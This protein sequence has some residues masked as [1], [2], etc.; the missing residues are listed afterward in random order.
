M[1]SASR[2]I[3]KDSHPTV[4]AVSETKSLKVRGRRYTN[5]YASSQPGAV[6]AKELAL[7][8]QFACLSITDDKPNTLRNV[9]KANPWQLNTIIMIAGSEEKAH[10]PLTT[11]LDDLFSLKLDHHMDISGLSKAGHALDTQGYIAHNDEIIVLAYRCTTSAKD[12]ITNLTTTSSAWELD[13]DVEQGHSGY[14]SSCVGFGC[15]PC[16]SPDKKSLNY[17]P[18]RVHT[19]F[20]NNFLVTVP[21]I[22]QYLDPLLLAPDQPPRTLYVVG[23]S[24]GAGIAIMA[25][26]YFLMEDQRYDWRNMPHKLRVVTAGGPRA[27]CQSMQQ[28]MDT[29]C[30]DLRYTD[31]VVLARMVRDKDVV[32]T[33]PPE[34]FGFRHLNEKLVYITKESDPTETGGGGFGEVLVNPDLRQVLSK[35]QVQQF[36][37]K[38]PEILG[39][40]TQKQQQQ[41]L[42]HTDTESSAEED[43]GLALTTTTPCTPQSTAADDGT[44]KETEIEVCETKKNNTND[45]SNIIAEESSSCVESVSIKAAK[46]DKFVKCVPRAFRDHMPDFYL[47]P[48]LHLQ[49]QEALFLARASEQAWEDTDNINSPT[50]TTTTSAA[51]NLPKAI[52]DEPANEASALDYEPLRSIGSSCSSA[53]EYKIEKPR[54]LGRF[55]SRPKKTSA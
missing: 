25:A 53:K 30:Q 38:Q 14:F 16:T 19:G 20:Y 41:L 43:N 42:D 45:T 35:R 26:C 24:L 52:Y 7:G 51:K 6:Q 44:F 50:A 34:M 5:T 18:P 49:E 47:R 23:H 13:L 15:F 33:V 54:G 32:P 55:F 9:A 40:A 31:K 46:Y 27:C 1:P 8:M 17:A 4:R 3:T 39:T 37:E 36:R 28:A 22:R 10:L 21:L 2:Y 11:L 29:K 48:L 12:W